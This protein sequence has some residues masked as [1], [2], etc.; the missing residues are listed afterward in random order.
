MHLTISLPRHLLITMA[1][2]H[3]ILGRKTTGRM[4][5]MWA[6]FLTTGDQSTIMRLRAASDRA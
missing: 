2:I 6:T 1:M 5:E 3:L 4:E